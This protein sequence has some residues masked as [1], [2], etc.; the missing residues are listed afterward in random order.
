MPIAGAV[1]SLASIGVAIY[2]WYAIGA[3][4]SGGLDVIA[5]EL[6]KARDAAVASANDGT[7]ATVDEV[8][9][10]YKADAAK[11]ERRKAS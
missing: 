5:K 9:K 7:S 11:A 6:Q 8:L 3:A 2:W 10:A 4:V 1:V